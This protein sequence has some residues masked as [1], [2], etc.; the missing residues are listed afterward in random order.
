M[1]E[2]VQQEGHTK[3]V[4]SYCISSKMWE[5]SNIPQP[6]VV[7]SLQSPMIPRRKSQE[8]RNGDRIRELED[9]CG[10]TSILTV[11]EGDEQTN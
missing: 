10:N 11:E 4:N 9:Y 3:K 2:G 5:E 7:Q 6:L 8:D 1:N